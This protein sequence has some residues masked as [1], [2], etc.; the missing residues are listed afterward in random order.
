[1]YSC[2]VQNSV[3]KSFRGKPVS[4]AEK[5]FGRP[6]EILAS[7][8]DSVYVFEKTSEFQSTE[9]NQGRFSHTPIITPKVKKTERF[10]FSVKNG[11]IY[12]TLVEEKYNR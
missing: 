10:Y 2:G 12:K 9:I 11:L 8:G 1:M 3:K 5:Q 6:V 4:M 7:D